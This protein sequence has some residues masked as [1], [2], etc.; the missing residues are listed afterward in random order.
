M[1]TQLEYYNKQ[2]IMIINIGHPIVGRI[3]IIY[4]IINKF[5]RAIF[6]CAPLFIYHFTAMVYTEYAADT[7]KKAVPIF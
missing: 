4:I 1:Q 5:T 7:G 3:V 6:D 2:T